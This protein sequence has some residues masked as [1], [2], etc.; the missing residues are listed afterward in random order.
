MLSV[1][2]ELLWAFLKIGFFSIGGGYAVIPMI[3]EVVV[4]QNGWVGRQAFTDMIT[5]SQMTP[6][7]LAVNISTFTGMQIAGVSGALT[8]TLGCVI[9]GI[10]IAILLHRFF[11]KHRES[12]YVFEVLNGL[13]AASLGLIVSASATIL[14]M[15]FF[16]NGV[17][18]L[19]GLDIRAVAVFGISLVLLRKWKINPI[20]LLALTGIAGLLS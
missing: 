7:P 11:Q 12:V 10:L 5:I 8:A 14:V 1:L 4:R 19:A 9:S 15:A 6:G 18:S 13:K 17:V 16:R 20:L 3:E 2:S